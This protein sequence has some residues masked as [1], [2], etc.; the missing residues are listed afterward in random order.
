ML[1][2]LQSTYQKIKTG[3][4]KTRSLLAGKIHSIFGRPWN[5]ETFE[6]LEKTLYESDL[7]ATCAAH[8]TEEMRKFLRKHPT[9]T[10]DQILE[11]L[12]KGAL[13]ILSSPPKALP[14]EPAPGDPLVLMVI[15]VNG[16]G[17][18]TTIGKLAALF[19]KEG[20]KVLIAAADTFRAAAVEQL[21]HWAEK[22]KVPIVRA[23]TGSDPSSVVFDALSAAKARG[24]DIVIIDTAGRLQNKADLMQELEKMK[25]VSIKVFPGAPHE[26]FL[27]VDS[28]T[29]QNAIDQ[30]K[31]FHQ[32]LPLT[33]IVLTKL[34]GSSKGGIVLSIYQQMG[35]PIRFVGLGENIEDLAPFDPN[36]YIEAL[37]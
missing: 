4:Q 35:I 22:A 6:E 21:A 17:K 30:A 25:R 27:V 26:T 14:K 18:T 28:N 37:F 10:S 34:D 29:G 16:S 23:Q 15:G 32:I 2:F 7:G 3:L 19:Q 1:R 11:E 24:V 36:A 31:A 20:K 13:Q 8:F 9:A 33:G 5:E 12:R